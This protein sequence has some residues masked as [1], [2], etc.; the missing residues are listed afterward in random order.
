MSVYGLEVRYNN[1][2]PLRC[3]SRERGGVFAHLYTA[4]GGNLRL[5][6][7]I[8]K[9]CES[10]EYSLGALV[11]GDMFTF[12]FLRRSRSGKQSIDQ[13]PRLARKPVVWRATPK[14]RLGLD[15]RLKT[16]DTVR[17]SHPKGGGFSFMLGN[18]PLDHARA[19]VMA[20][21]RKEQWHWQLNDL[22]PDEEIALHIVETDWCD[23]PPV[24]K[25]VEA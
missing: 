9:D 1:Q 21:N 14:F 5:D 22:N 11:P 3:F 6:V 17:T 2:T 7:T 4:K 24:V 16:G 25:P 10:K 13:L 20:W 15:I 23:E 12:R 8:K 18:I 19:F